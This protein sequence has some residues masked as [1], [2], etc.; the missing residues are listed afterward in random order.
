[1]YDY[2]TNRGVPPSRL[3]LEESSRDSAENV[4]NA[5]G[6]IR[7][8][9]GPEANVRVLMVTCKFHMMRARLLGRDQGLE[10]GGAPSKTEFEDLHYYVREYFSVMIYL[11]ER[12]GVTLDTSW[13]G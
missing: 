11:V 1:M 6:V 9:E 2:L 8:R 10:A 3:L 5:A 13:F 7:D 12:N 4:A